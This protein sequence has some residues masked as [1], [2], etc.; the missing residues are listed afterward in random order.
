[1]TGLV[2]R[3]A[4]DVFRAPEPQPFP[5][6]KTDLRSRID[7]GILGRFNWATFKSIF[8]FLVLAAIVVVFSS[9]SLKFLNQANIINI[10]RM[11]VPIMLVSCAA[12][13]IMIS[14]N[15]DLSVGSIVGLS[16]VMYCIMLQKGFGFFWSVVLTMGLGVV[17]GYINGLLVMRLRIVPVIAT[18]VTLYLFRGIAWTLTPRQIGLIKGN[19]PEGINDF[20]RAPVLFGL[21]WAFYTAVAVIVVMV[22]VQRKTILGKYSAAIGGNLVAAELSGINVVG[23]VWILYMLSGVLSSVAGIARASY[24]SM[25]DPMTG[26]LMELEVILAVLLG[27]TRFYG[28]EG[29]ILKTIIGAL[30]IMCVS[31][32]MT[33]L[34]IPPYWQSFAKGVVL[35]GT[36]AIYTLITEKVE[37]VSC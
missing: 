12:T 6:L 37:K 22:V 7:M 11:A 3:D 32:G 1:M 35:I 27:G 2:E 30:I 14:A 29:S 21:P 13:L 24:L 31:V 15:I 19:L 16:G 36:L 18:L 26:N 10:L 5:V 25:G 20:A 4:A 28:G 33:V 8:V 34:W 23:T 9:V 17:M